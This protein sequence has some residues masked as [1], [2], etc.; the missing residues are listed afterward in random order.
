MQAGR[1]LPRTYGH[2]TSMRVCTGAKS[3]VHRAPAPETYTLTPLRAHVSLGIK[4]HGN[5][6]DGEVVD[7]GHGV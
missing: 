1:Q 6:K 7:V 3:A 2:N 4:A 5:G